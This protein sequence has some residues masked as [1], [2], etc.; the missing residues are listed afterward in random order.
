VAILRPSTK[1]IN[2]QKRSSEIALRICNLCVFITQT[3]SYRSIILIY[4]KITTITIYLFILSK[5]SRCVTIF[6]YIIFPSYT[7]SLHYHNTFT[8]Y[9]FLATCFGRLFA[10]IIRSSMRVHYGIPYCVQIIIKIKFIFKIIYNSDKNLLY[11]VSSLCVWNHW[12][13]SLFKTIH[14][15]RWGLVL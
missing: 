2:S 12:L 11:N 6:Q 14:C 8:C 9:N 13:K 1:I 4:C 10:N 3:I 15:L 7:T 5:P